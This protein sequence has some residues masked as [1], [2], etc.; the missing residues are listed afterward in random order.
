MSI[1]AINS[2]SNTVSISGLTNPYTVLWKN[3]AV[4]FSANYVQAFGTAYC[5]GIHPEFKQTTGNQSITLPNGQKYQF[6]YDPR[7]GLL[8]KIIYP[9]GGY[10]SY[11]W[12]FNP[13]SESTTFPDAQAGTPNSSGGTC[14]YNY[15]SPAVTHRYVSFDGVKIA[16]Q[17]DFTYSTIWEPNVAG[18]WKT[19]QTTVT[20]NDLIRGTSFNTIYTYA[21]RVDEGQSA[22]EQ[23]IVYQDTIGKT[24]R[25]VTKAWY[26][27]SLLGCE[28]EQWDSG[29][30]WAKFYTYATSGG[31]LTNKKEYDFGLVSSSSA[32]SYS[33]MTIPPIVPPSVTPTRETAITYAI[34]DQPS[35]VITYGNGAKAA[36]KDYRSNQCHTC[37]QPS[38][39]NARRDELWTQLQYS[40]QCHHRHSK[41]L[42]ELR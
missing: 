16:L 27:P 6:E 34:F 22:T 8:S 41:M 7:F 18:F 30:I 9:S 17:Q 21:P 19:R 37:C 10:V 13:L 11:T 4:S 40:R 20:T 29:V 3:S 26:D 32:C 15:D 42:A 23:S 33:N 25:T 1:S 39:W 5:Q 12:G 31:Y 2:N 24:L 14:T 36:E 35:K 28:L 38:F